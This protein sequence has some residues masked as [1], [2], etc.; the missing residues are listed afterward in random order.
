MHNYDF[1]IS[2][3]VTFKC[4]FYVRCLC[5]ASSVTYLDNCCHTRSS[6][7]PIHVYNWRSK[8]IQVIRNCSVAVLSLPW[9]SCDTG[10]TSWASFQSPCQRSPPTISAI[11]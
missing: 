10:T 7:I 8:N 1:V 3:I 11:L 5:F 2:S 4:M 9:Q 6:N